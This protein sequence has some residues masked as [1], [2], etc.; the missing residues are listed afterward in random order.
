MELPQR[1]AVNGLHHMDSNVNDLCLYYVIATSWS[2]GS[3]MD[4]DFHT[5]RQKI[6]G[7]HELQTC[8][9]RVVHVNSLIS[10]TGD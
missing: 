5:R 7:K 9:W 4:D 10:W 8:P 1:V 3:L 6:A 2:K